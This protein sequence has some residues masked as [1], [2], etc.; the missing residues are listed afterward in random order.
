[1]ILTGMGSDGCEG[2]RMLHQKG[3]V[4]WAQNEDTCVVYG[5]PQAV[6]YAGIADQI[7]PLEKFADCIAQ[8]MR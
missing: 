4:V 1:M 3:S 7:L 8:E 2:C 6:V 5:M